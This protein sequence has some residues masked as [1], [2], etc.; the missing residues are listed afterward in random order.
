MNSAPNPPVSNLFDGSGGPLPFPASVIPLANGLTVIH[1]EIPA[2]PVVV[3]DVWIRAGARYEPLAW[4]GMAHFLEHMVFKGTEKILPGM[5]DAAIESRGG[6][7]NAATSHDYAHFYMTIAADDLDHAL[8]YLADLLLQAAI[9]D[10]EFIRERQVVVEEIHQSWDDPD[11]VG[12]QTLS[13]MLYGEHPYGRSVLGTPEILQARSPE[14][15]R[16]FHRT[17]YQP[18]NMRVVIAGGV[19]RERVVDLVQKTFHTFPQPDA[20][21]QA[22]SASLRQLE[23]YTQ[24]TLALPR[25]EH[26]RLMMAWLGPGMGELQAACGLDI[27]ATVLAEGRLS[28][29]V[30]ELREDRQWVDDIASSFSVQ[31]DCSLFMLSSWLEPTYIKEVEQVICD[32]IASLATIPITEIELER[33]QRVLCNDYAFSMETPGQLAGLYGYYG[34]LATPEL[35]LAY[36]HYVQDYSPQELLPLAQ[37]YLS[38][39][40]CATLA[41][42]PQ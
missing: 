27:L 5:F 8:P 30:R 40:H 33:A 37:Q 21:P 20:C 15:M 34:T 16:Q 17:Y 6:L 7:T 19:S 1:Q 22:A 36:P 10:D 12:F 28:R 35:S 2:T 42:I 11:A 3:V 24:Q 29:L 41:L 23:N 4:A 18:G 31:E 38:P 26:G 32:R 13:E 9:P 39:N 14:E 25:L